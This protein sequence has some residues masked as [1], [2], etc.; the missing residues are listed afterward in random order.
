MVGHRISFSDNLQKLKFSGHFSGP[1][2]LSWYDV[3]STLKYS[4]AIELQGD[5]LFAHT[6][7]Y[8]SIFV[9]VHRVTNT[10]ATNNPFEPP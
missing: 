3:T 6:I 7:K 4:P 10:A 2:A 9:I 5:M 8:D 1:Y